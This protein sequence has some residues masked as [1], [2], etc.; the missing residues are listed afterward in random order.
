M[1]SASEARP[2]NGGSLDTILS[3]FPTDGH[4]YFRPAVPTSTATSSPTCSRLQT[5][6]LTLGAAEIPR[7]RPIPST[8]PV[9]QR[10]SGSSFS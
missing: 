7:F 10:S 9:E 4:R 5:E 2:A 3:D 6:P 8:W 1:R